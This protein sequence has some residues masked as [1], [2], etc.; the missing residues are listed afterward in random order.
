MRSIFENGSEYNYYNRKETMRVSMKTFNWVAL[1]FAILLFN[2]IPIAKAVQIIK[3]DPTTYQFAP[4]PALDKR[5]AIFKKL[6]TA[7]SLGMGIGP[8]LDKLEE[9]EIAARKGEPEDTLIA[10]IDY[11]TNALN[12]QYKTMD[13]GMRQSKADED[14]STYH[15]EL[16]RKLKYNWHPPKLKT[17]YRVAIGFIAQKDGTLTNIKVVQSSGFKPLDDAAIAAVKSSSPANPWPKVPDK[18][19]NA[20]LH[21]FMSSDANPAPYQKKGID[22][23]A[24]G[25]SDTANKKLESVADLTLDIKELSRPSDADSLPETASFFFKRGEHGHM[26]VD[27]VVNGHPVKAIFDTGASAF[28]YDEPLKKAGVDINNA[29]PAGYARGWAGVSIPITQTDAEIKLGN[30]QRKLPIRIAAAGNDFSTNL[31]GQDFIYGYQYSI[32]DKAGRVDLH[33]KLKKEANFDP[34]YDIPCHHIASKDIIEV[35]I[36]GHKISAFIDTGSFATII[37]Y[38]TAKAIGLDLNGELERGTGVGGSISMV[39]DYVTI[40]VGPI[41]KDEFCVRIGGFAGCCIGQDLME[42]WRYKVDRDEQLM[43]FFH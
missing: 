10:K 24:P 12:S 18:K 20:I 38:P 29:Q 30:F 34:L 36:N 33:K 41:K 11:L 37:D 15:K 22:V 40:R 5:Q 13:L 17:P 21:Y 6:L 25:A 2:A 4:G 27:L 19:Q 42:G 3:Q 35:E 26:N 9:I 16:L 1:F 7:K 31:I 39:K 8:Y 23:P 43:H 32:D 28:F 14:W